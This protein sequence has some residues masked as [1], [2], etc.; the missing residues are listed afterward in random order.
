MQQ[1]LCE[2]RRW[3]DQ[4]PPSVPRE[5]TIITV[6]KYQQQRDTEAGGGEPGGGGGAAG[7]LHDPCPEAPVDG[8]GRESDSVRAR[9]GY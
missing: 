9:G 2:Q 7:V 6:T 3:Q 1:A 4:H 5:T 8:A